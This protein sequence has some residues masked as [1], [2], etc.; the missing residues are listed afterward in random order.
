M[1][2]L[3]QK[4]PMKQETG[5]LLFTN[6]SPCCSDGWSVDNQQGI[7]A[8]TLHWLNLLRMGLMT[9]EARKKA[10]TQP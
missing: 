4:H 2:C 5:Q 10:R 7:A 8:A 1:I 6:P 3:G 9:T